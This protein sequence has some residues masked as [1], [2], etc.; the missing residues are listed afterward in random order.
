LPHCFVFSKTGKLGTAL[1]AMSVS[2][3][4]HVRFGVV[5]NENT[6]VAAKLGLHVKAGQ[7]STYIMRLQVAREVRVYQYR[8]VKKPGPLFAWMKS[9]AVAVKKGQDV[10]E[11]AGP[12]QV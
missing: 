3:K 7:A 4:E 11:S 12:Y 10:P 8:G 6:E 5:L 1:K 9:I 2:L